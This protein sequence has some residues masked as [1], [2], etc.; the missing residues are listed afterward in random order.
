MSNPRNFCDQTMKLGHTTP[1]HEDK[2]LWLITFENMYNEIANH[3]VDAYWQL[4]SKKLQVFHINTKQRRKRRN[5]VW[6]T[7]QPTWMNNILWKQGLPNAPSSLI[8]CV[9][10]REYLSFLVAYNQINVLKRR[11]HFIAFCLL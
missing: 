10:T 4:K 3:H 2:R 1:Q 5:K 7:K 9:Y 11:I 6:L 8:F